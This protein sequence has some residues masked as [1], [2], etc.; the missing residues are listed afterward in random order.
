MIYDMTH[1]LFPV[2]NAKLSKILVYIILCLTSG[3]S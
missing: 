3:K 1:P 2:Y